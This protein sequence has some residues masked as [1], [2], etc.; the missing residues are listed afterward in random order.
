MLFRSLA[1]YK[2]V[3]VSVAQAIRFRN[4]GALDL[5]RLQIKNPA[6]GKLYRVYGSEIFL[7]LGRVQGEEMAIARLL[8][9]A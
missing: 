2:S 5:A 3:Q 9:T 7:G 8:V 6:E 4:G 1:A